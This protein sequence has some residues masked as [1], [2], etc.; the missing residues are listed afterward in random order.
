[1]AEGAEAEAQLKSQSRNILTCNSCSVLCVQ[2]G[3]DLMSNIQHQMRKGRRSK[4][5]N[6]IEEVKGEDQIFGWQRL[7]DGRQHPVSGQVSR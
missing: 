3:I 5:T 4:R 2:I 7:G 1:M 6:F